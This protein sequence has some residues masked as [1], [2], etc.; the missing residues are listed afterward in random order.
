[1]A[2]RPRGPTAGR[3]RPAALLPSVTPN[4]NWVRLPQRVPVRIRLDPLPPDVRLVARQ[5]V[6]VHVLPTR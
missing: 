2:C 6:T 4:F 3:H 5:T 1:M